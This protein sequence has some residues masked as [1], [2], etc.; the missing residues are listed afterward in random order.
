VLLNSYMTQGVPLPI[1]W[2]RAQVQ[3]SASLPGWSSGAMMPL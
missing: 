1:A 3:V 2:L